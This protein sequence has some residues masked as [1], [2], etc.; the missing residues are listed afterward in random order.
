[1]SASPE[2]CG[3]DCLLSADLEFFDTLVDPLLA[4]SARFSGEN[5]KLANSIEGLRISC[6]GGLV[7]EE[8]DVLRG[9]PEE[10]D[11]AVES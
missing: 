6:G 8:N 9:G 3:V 5:E 10:V 11:D 4:G 1:M 7:I 2:G